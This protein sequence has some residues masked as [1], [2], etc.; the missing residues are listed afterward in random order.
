M[1]SLFPV[2]INNSL[3]VIKVFAKV[4]YLKEKVTEHFLQK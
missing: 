2:R 4:S 3:Q 1:L